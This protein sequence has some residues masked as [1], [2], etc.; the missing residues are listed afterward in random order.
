MNMKQ[1]KSSGSDNWDLMEE[2][3]ERYNLDGVDVLRL[4]T[5]WHGTWLIDG[6]FM[7]DLIDCEGYEV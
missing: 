3:I 2:I 1:W 5:N 4:L 7:E 6:N